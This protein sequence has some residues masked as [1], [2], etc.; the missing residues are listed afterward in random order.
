M[1]R[2]GIHRLP[3][4]RHRRHKPAYNPHQA[5]LRES[6]QRSATAHLRPWGETE[7]LPTR[8][9]LPKRQ[10]PRTPQIQIHRRVRVGVG[11]SSTPKINLNVA[12]QNKINQNMVIDSRRMSISNIL[13]TL[14]VGL[15]GILSV[16]KSSNAARSF[17]LNT[18]S[19][20]IGAKQPPDL[21]Y[22][23]VFDFK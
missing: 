7:S 15:L 14:V 11:C 3:N 21:V 9:V 22:P 18:I 4:G 16:P 8:W 23:P 1:P 5:S 12:L 10:Q 20:V 19:E 17:A 6:P 13:Y 2:R